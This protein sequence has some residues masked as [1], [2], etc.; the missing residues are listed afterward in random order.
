MQRSAGHGADA[1]HGT[2]G[3]AQSDAE[4]LHV[5]TASPDCARAFAQRVPLS[6]P[7]SG[8]PLQIGVRPGLATIATIGRWV[9]AV[10]GPRRLH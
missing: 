1:P 5:G 4:T 9:S 10:F 2:P 7:T 3:E 8:I 6:A